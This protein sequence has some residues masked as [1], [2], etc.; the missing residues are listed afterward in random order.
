MRESIC[1]HCPAILTHD[2]DRT[3]EV[4]ECPN[5][6]LQTKLLGESEPEKPPV[7]VVEWKPKCQRC[8]STCLAPGARG[9]SI[10]GA[11]L[12]GILL[13]VVGVIFGFV[14]ASRVELTCL[15]CGFRFPP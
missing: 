8:E 11:I 10:W 3:G 4:V 13:P 15:K 5:C 6:H 1:H 14:G 12:G 7:A 2:A 9:F